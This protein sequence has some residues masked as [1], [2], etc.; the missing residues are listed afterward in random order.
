MQDVLAEVV[1]GWL[2]FV[3][4]SQRIDLALF[5]S[6]DMH[7]HIFSISKSKWG[8]FQTVYVALRGFSR[9]GLSTSGIIKVLF[10]NSSAKL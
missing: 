4:F 1:S 5:K 3:G 2:Y 9:F 6:F 10:Q 8:I 7:M